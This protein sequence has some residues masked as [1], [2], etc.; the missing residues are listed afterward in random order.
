M[1]LPFLRPTHDK[2]SLD[3]LLRRRLASLIPAILLQEMP[4]CR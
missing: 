2:A 4:L 3:T 1:R